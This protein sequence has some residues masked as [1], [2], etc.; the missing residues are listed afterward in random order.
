MSVKF[1]S[2]VFGAVLSLAAVFAVALSPKQL[3]E[4]EN[5]F[6]GVVFYKNHV[7][8]G[9]GMYFAFELQPDREYNYEVTTDGVHWEFVQHISM[10]GVTHEIY[11]SFNIPD[12]CNGIWPRIID[13]GPS[14]Q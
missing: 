10:K 12:P 4:V 8:G 1:K 7:S 9:L 11:E 13:L 5:P 3:V 14:P 6:A 2:L